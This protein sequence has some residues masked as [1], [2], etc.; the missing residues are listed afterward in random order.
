MI[1]YI[2]E[3]G[4][5]LLHKIIEIAWITTEEIPNDWKEAIVVPTYYIENNKM[6]HNY[7]MLTILLVA[8]KIDEKCWKEK[9]A[10][11]TRHS[12]LA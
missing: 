10:V 4:I 12:K 2:G 1:Q 5:K 7:R 8:Y 3:E 6:C 9:S 11:V